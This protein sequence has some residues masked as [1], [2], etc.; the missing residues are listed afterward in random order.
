MF[1]LGGLRAEFQEVTSQT[2][3]DLPG[4]GFWD[5][6]SP[7]SIHFVINSYQCKSRAVPES[8]REKDATGEEPPSHV[9]RGRPYLQEPSVPAFCNAPSVPSALSVSP[10]PSSHQN[11]PLELEPGSL[12]HLIGKSHPMKA[13]GQLLSPSNFYFLYLKLF[14]LP[15]LSERVPLL[16]SAFSLPML[17]SH[18]VFRN[19]GVGDVHAAPHR[20]HPGSGASAQSS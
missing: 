17:L 5:T 16:L 4:L 18:P 1:F 13:V 6:H 3:Q 11:S 8:G 19:K 20:K 7:I 9:G 10:C 15:A 14:S 12:W 2:S